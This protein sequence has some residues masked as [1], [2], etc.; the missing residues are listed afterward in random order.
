M[1][2]ASGSRLKDLPKPNK[3]DDESQANDAVNR[4]KLLK[5]DARTVAAQQVARLE[6]AMCLRRRWSPE[7]FQLFLVEHPLV[8]HL[9][10]R[11]IWGVY[12]AENQANPASESAEQ[13][14]FTCNN[15]GYSASS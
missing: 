6:S 11:L 1:R 15:P 4:Y 8:R 14:S 3:S 12:S 2:D 10:R 13:T 5:K 7:N 9:T